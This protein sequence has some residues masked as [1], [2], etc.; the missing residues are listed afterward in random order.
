MTYDQAIILQHAT[1]ITD[2]WT[3]SYK[4]ALWLRCGWIIKPDPYWSE[5]TL[6]CEE[7]NQLHKV[8]KDKQIKSSSSRIF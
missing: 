4:E 7:E 6:H 8:T 5:L 3:A 2:F 1:N